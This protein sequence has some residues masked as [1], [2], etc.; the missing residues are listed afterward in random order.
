MQPRSFGTH[1]G[2]FH[3]DEVSACALLLLEDL[4]D[5][6]KIIR[7]RDPK[8]LNKCEYVCDVGG[9]Y[10]PSIKRFDHHQVEY[11]GELSSAGM[12]LAYLKEKEFFSQDFY[13]FLNN[14][15]IRGVDAH[16]NGKILLKEGVC[17]FSHIISNFLPIDYNSKAKERFLAFI[18]AVTFAHEHIKRL[19]NRY[20]YTQNC[21]DIVEKV[22]QQNVHYLQFEEPIPWMDNFF[23]L[24]GES[25]PALFVIMPTGEHWKLRGI[26]P[27]SKEKMR[28]RLL[29]PINW[30]GLRGEDL[31]KAS[32][33]PGA[34]FC[35]KGRF[36]SIWEN[37]KDA[38]AALKTILAQT[39]VVL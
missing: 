4:I 36:I 29:L 14:S 23:D 11:K 21:R 1:D 9:V 20:I 37:K 2:S 22:M 10:D 8:L 12:V 24:G 13:R 31:A 34:I 28:V 7:S 19:R 38:L 3:A 39:G 15:L 16:D 27:N 17:T 5:K 33:V 30:A 32:K 18:E 25:H 6:D 26:P 35:H